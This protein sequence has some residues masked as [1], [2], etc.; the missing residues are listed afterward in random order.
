MVAVGVCACVCVCLKNW[1]LIEVIVSSLI[2]QA[3]Q[4]GALYVPAAS[5]GFYFHGCVFG[6]RKVSHHHGYY[7]VASP[8]TG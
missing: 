2:A 5:V 8:S 1:L 3:A 6:Y 4:Q 7:G